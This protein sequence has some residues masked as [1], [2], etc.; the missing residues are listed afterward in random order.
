M[1]VPSSGE[2]SLVGIALEMSQN[3]YQGHVATP[4]NQG[5]DGNIVGPTSNYPQ[6]TGD[7]GFYHPA[8]FLYEEDHANYGNPT[9]KSRDG[10]P[11]TNTAPFSTQ[12]ATSARGLADI[13]LGGMSSTS[14]TYSSGVVAPVLNPAPRT[15]ANQQTYASGPTGL[16]SGTP[17]QVQ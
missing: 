14:Y 2:L 4:S 10:T 12:D 5:M 15:D 16:T 3:L 11:P 7:N 9:A 6:A 8:Y 17:L 13:S 1:A